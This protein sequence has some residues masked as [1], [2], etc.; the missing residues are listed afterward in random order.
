VGTE[1]GVTK[2]AQKF[3]PPPAGGILGATCYKLMFTG[4]L[5]VFWVLQKVLH[6]V[7]PADRELLIV[8]FGFA[9][10]DSFEELLQSFHVRCCTDGLQRLKLLAGRRCSF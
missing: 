3:S 9:G 8:N 7:L 10:T 2:V 4:V 5:W 1:E 6:R